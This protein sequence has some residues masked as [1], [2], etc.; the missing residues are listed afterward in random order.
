MNKKI[1]QIW[2]LSN[3]ETLEDLDK[4]GDGVVNIDG[5]ILILFI[6]KIEEFIGK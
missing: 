5:K 3:Q 2:I 6:L 4:N 1:Y